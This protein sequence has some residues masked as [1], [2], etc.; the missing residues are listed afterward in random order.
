M[1][2]AQ[3]SK[4]EGGTTLSGSDAKSSKLDGNAKD[5]DDKRSRRARQVVDIAEKKK[6]LK[7]RERKGILNKERTDGT[8]KGSKCRKNCD[9]QKNSFGREQQDAVQKKL[10]KTSSQSARK[11]QKNFRKQGLSNIPEGNKTSYLLNGV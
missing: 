9:C 6:A 1:P 4:M 8:K 11:S 5:F 7:A 10:E 2:L 3:A